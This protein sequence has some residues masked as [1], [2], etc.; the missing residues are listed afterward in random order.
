[1]ALVYRKRRSRGVVKTA[2]Y[3]VYLDAAISM[4]TDMLEYMYDYSV[5]LCIPIHKTVI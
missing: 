3:L 1:M 5:I 4:I 2:L